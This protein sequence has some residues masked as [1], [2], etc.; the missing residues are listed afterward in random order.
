MSGLVRYFLA[1]QGPA[2]DPG[3]LPRPQRRAMAPVQ[4]RLATVALQVRVATVA[5]ETRIATVR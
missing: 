1:V 3:A 5:A 2:P 4:L